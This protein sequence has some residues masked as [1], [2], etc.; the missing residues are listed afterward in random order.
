MTLKLRLSS[1]ASSSSPPLS[2]SPP[3][4]GAAGAARRHEP[5]LRHQQATPTLAQLRGVLERAT[6]PGMP[7]SATRPSPGS[8]GSTSQRRAAEAVAAEGSRGRHGVAPDGRAAEPERG[9]GA[10]RR[11]WAGT[12]RP[13]TR[14]AT[15]TRGSSS[16]LRCSGGWPRPLRRGARARPRRGS[17]RTGPAEEDAVEV[18]GAG[19]GG[20]D[21]PTAREGRDGD[22]EG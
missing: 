7:P 9:H 21:G 16:A 8:R 5:G 17:T 14:R 6:S 18:G 19:G 2:P 12:P 4:A 15:R 20:Q 11:G 1:V 22:R 13:R 10:D 3:L